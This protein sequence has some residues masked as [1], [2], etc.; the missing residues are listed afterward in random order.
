MLH[1]ERIPYPVGFDETTR[2]VVFCLLDGEPTKISKIQYPKLQHGTTIRK[3][4]TLF[5][6]SFCKHYKPL[7]EKTLRGKLEFHFLP[8]LA[9]PPRLGL[10]SVCFP[11]STR[12]A[13]KC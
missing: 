5:L 9:I 4:I 3:Y 12:S 6:I 10:K 7:F 2:F 1:D 13:K 8:K 11:L